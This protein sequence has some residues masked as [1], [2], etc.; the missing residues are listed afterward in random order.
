MK[1]QYIAGLLLIMTSLIWGCSQSAPEETEESQSE[2]VIEQT[3][4]PSLEKKDITPVTSEPAADTAA[5]DGPD[6]YGR[7]PGDEHYGHAHAPKDETQ[8]NPASPAVGAPFA[9]PAAPASG[10]PDKY[11]RNPGEEHYGHDHE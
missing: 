8:G 11:G 10:E 3:E 9:S 7:M 6:Q 5:T 4:A 2:Q 1:L